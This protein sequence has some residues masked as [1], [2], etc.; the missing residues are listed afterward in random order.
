[1]HLILFALLIQGLL[2]RGGFGQRTIVS[3]LENGSMVDIR[4]VPDRLA[5]DG[6]PRTEEISNISEFL[7][8]VLIKT[9]TFVEYQIVPTSVDSVSSA[10]LCR[11]IQLAKYYLPKVSVECDPDIEVVEMGNRN[12][13]ATGLSAQC[14]KLYVND[15][16]AHHQTHLERMQMPAVWDLI[17]QYPRRNV[18][19]AVIDGGVDFTDP[20]LAPL[21][22][23][24]TLSNG[25]VIDGGWN[26]VN[27]SAT[28]HPGVYHGQYISRVAA[29]RGNNSYGMIGVMPDHVNLIALQVLYN[30]KGFTGAGLEAINVAID[31]GVDV[32]LISSTVPLQMAR[33]SRKAR[34]HGIVTVFAAGNSNSVV[35]NPAICANSLCVTSL[36]NGESFFLSRFA[37]YGRD[38]AL[39]AFGEDI[40]VGL[41]AAGKHHWASGTSY[42]APMV[43]GAAAILLSIDTGG[44]YLHPVGGAL[45]ILASVKKAISMY[46]IRPLVG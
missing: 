24:F 32:I 36:E 28:Y 7:S 25:T 12:R 6:V 27:N 46:N 45:N 3:V 29:A 30:G 5:R 1:M 15:P 10:A 4:S 41:D 43:A 42:S 11:Y 21:R 39:A 37:N 31:I 40:Y 34:M 26:F 8:T 17:K 35:S 9:L 44:K 14:A 38:V 13:R 23:S 2:Y 33:I 22:S 18:T 20:D 19:I 16:D